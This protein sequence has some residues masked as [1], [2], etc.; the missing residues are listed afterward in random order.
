M[1]V[2]RSV[3]GEDLLPRLAA[4]AQ[5]EP[6]VVARDVDDPPP[7]AAVHVDERVVGHGRDAY[8]RLLDAL[9]RWEL[10]EAAGMVSVA[11]GD[12]APG[13]TVL[14]AA[15]AGPVRV[16]VPCRVLALVGGGFDYVTLP[17][18]PVAGVER[19]AVTLG[20][21][22]AV[23]LTLRSWSVP[24][25]IARACPPAL[26]LGQWLGNRRYLDAAERLLRA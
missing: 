25:G 9:L 24:A 20:R 11:T 21:D 19:F 22:G 8:W 7:G 12:A 18:N 3:T 17:G 23:S 16:T 4:L 1:F 2:Q 5:L 10:H 14:N 15:A 6:N 13:V 26:R